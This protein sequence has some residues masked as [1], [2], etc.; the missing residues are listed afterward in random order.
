[1]A[2]ELR[3]QDLGLACRGKVSADDEDELV[4]K[5]A[6][7]ARTKHSVELTETLIDYAKTMAVGEGS[8]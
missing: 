4:R 2:V 7:H 6:E 1:M 8:R 5:V 3:C